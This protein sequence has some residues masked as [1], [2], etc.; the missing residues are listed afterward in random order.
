M[1]GDALA[2]AADDSDTTV[3]RDLHPQRY[4]GPIDMMTCRNAFSGRY[5]GV[6]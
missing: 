2:P 4:A 3:A 5:K 6:S 1:A